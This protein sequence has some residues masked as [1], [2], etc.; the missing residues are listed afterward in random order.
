MWED[1]HDKR[2]ARSQMIG[3]VL[4]TVLFIVWIQWLAP[5]YAPEED[6]AP[7]EVAQ[8]AP[9]PEDD[10]GEEPPAGPGEPPDPGDE[11]ADFLP[12]AATAEDEDEVYLENERLRVAFTP[13]G[14][15][16]TRAEVMLGAEDEQSIQLVPEGEEAS[17]ADRIYPLGLEFNDDKLGQQ[18]NRRAWELA[19]QSERRVVFSLELPNR[20]EVRKA[21]ELHPEAHLVD[22]EITYRNLGDEPQQLGMDR[23]PSYILHWGPNI[24]SGDTDHRLIPQ[25]LVWR[26][27]GDLDSMTTAELA[28]APGMVRGVMTLP[29]PEWI[30]VKSAHFVVGFRGLDE[31]A[32]GWVTGDEDA[33]RFGMANPAFQV[34]AGEERVD[35]FQLY[36]GP[37]EM[38]ALEAGWATLDEALRFFQSDW[39]A[40]MDSFSKFLL[41]LLNGVY[42][43][44]PNYGVAIIVLTAGVRLVILPLTYKQ[45]MSMKKMQALAPEMEEL[46]KQYSED[47]QELQKQTMQL[48]KDRGVNPLAGCLPI[49]LQMPV[50]ISL[51]RMLYVA[52]ELRGAPFVAWIDDLSQPDQLTHFAALS[53]VPLLSHFEYLNVLPI[54]AALTM[55]ASFRLMPQ[56]AAAQHPQQKMIMMAM[57]L[58]FSIICYNFSSGLNLYILTSTLLGIAQ[59]FA[60]MKFGGEVKVEPQKKDKKLPRKKHFYDAAQQRKRQMAK[61]SRRQQQANPSGGQAQKRKKPSKTK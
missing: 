60:I 43:V 21:F 6:A 16:L 44:I 15:R 33:F 12:P 56:G 7:D 1:N 17:H 46:K 20:A 8:E 35:Q 48:Y 9:E 53:D 13:V 22:V 42:S 34:A 25:T 23:H 47:P 32:E 37:S 38:N 40:F 26:R 51:F 39:F 14:A 30:A 4:L 28:D 36:V 3:I 10:R 58:V 5:R 24:D 61:E 31:E 49:F 19:E 2:A 27:G 11:S 54:L 55:I 59:H 50:F 29:D 57:P 18:L 52:F 45:M 41:G